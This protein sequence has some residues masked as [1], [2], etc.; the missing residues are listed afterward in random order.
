MEEITRKYGLF[1][2]CIGD[3]AKNSGHIPSNSTPVHFPAF[4]Q[5]HPIHIGIP[6]HTNTSY[7]SIHA[8]RSTIRSNSRDSSLFTRCFT[9]TWYDCV[10]TGWR[11]V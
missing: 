7:T 6:P 8:R 5:Q 1:P 10:V 9:S 11:R 4:F 3:I 2:K